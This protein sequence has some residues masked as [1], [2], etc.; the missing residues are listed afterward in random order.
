MP[1]LVNIERAIRLCRLRGILFTYHESGFLSDI[2]QTQALLYYVLARHACTQNETL[3][4]SATEQAKPYEANAVTFN[5]HR[6]RYL[7]S[8]GVTP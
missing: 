3:W 6:Y 8:Q 5:Y 7:S 4:Q 1:A 2:S